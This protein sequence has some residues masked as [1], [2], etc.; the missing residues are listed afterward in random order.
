MFLN[1]A[2]TWKDLQLA[3]E[4]DGL[5][6]RGIRASRRVFYCGAAATIRVQSDIVSMHDGEPARILLDALADEVQVFFVE[7]AANA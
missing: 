3:L 5:S 1:L 4:D 2:A 7:Q 6:E